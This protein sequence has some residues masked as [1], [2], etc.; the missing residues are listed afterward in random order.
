MESRDLKMVVA[1]SDIRIVLCRS[2][3]NF[4]ILSSGGPFANSGLDRLNG[5][6]GHCAAAEDEESNGRSHFDLFFKLLLRL[7]LQ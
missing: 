4:E 2:N 5:E 6:S 7:F 3:K 1:N